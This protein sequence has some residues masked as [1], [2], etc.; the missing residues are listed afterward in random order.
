MILSI[1]I[2]SQKTT[3]IQ[4]FILNAPFES[5]FEATREFPTNLILLS[6]LRDISSYD[7]LRESNLSYKKVS[8]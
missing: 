2:I 4:I 5:F 8:Y 6:I 3:I 1:S 7:S